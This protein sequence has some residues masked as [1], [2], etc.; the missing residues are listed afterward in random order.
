MPFVLTHGCEL[1]I[2]KFAILLGACSNLSRRS[3]SMF[4]LYRCF[5]GLSRLRFLDRPRQFAWA[6]QQQSTRP[7]AAQGSTKTD[8]GGAD[9]WQP[10]SPS[11]A[12]GRGNQPAGG[13]PESNRSCPGPNDIMREIA[14]TLKPALSMSSRAK[15]QSQPRSR[16]RWGNSRS[17]AQWIFQ[18]AP[19]LDE[20]L[21]PCGGPSPRVQAFS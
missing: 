4:I 20:S 18:T 19:G 21:Q 16:P 1:R 15:V 14:G 17:R 8:F 9:G 13:L 5:R 2:C 12:S 10:K 11:T 7:K 6:F 3:D